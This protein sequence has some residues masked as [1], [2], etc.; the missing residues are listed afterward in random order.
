MS[1]FLVVVNN[2]NSLSTSVS[3]FEMTLINNV[4]CMTSLVH[5]HSKRRLTSGVEDY[6]G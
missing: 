3:N 6:R 2:T 4:Y 1:R 5:L